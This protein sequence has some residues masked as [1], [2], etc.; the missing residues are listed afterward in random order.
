MTKEERR[1]LSKELSKGVKNIRLEF[2]GPSNLA[3]IQFADAILKF[4]KEKK[5]IAQFDYLDNH[6]NVAKHKLLVDTNFLICD[7]EEMYIAD[8]RICTGEYLWIIKFTQAEYILYNDDIDLLI[9]LL[10]NNIEKLEEEV[11]CYIIDM[12]EKFKK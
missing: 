9:E 3:K 1:E 2:E 12:K 5:L 8:E 10:F 6:F 7:D 11:E 4:L